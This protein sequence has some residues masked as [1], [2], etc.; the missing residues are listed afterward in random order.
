MSDGEN[1]VTRT[2]VSVVTL[3]YDHDSCLVVIDGHGAHL[4]LAQMILDEGVRQ[5]EIQRRQAAALELQ[6][7]IEQARRDAAIAA[8]VRGRG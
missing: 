4:G 7:Q 6:A 8:A 1:G 3:T 5:L 2:K